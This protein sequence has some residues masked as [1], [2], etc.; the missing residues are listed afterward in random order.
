MAS[1]STARALVYRLLA[2]VFLPPQSGSFE[3]LMRDD[4]AALPDALEAL[5][6]NEELRSRAHELAHE[7]EAVHPEQLALVYEH[8]FEPSGGASKPPNETAHAPEIPQEGLTR[9]YEL[10]D[11]A[12]FY[13]A[14]G[15]EVA[16]ETERVD[17]I[18]A[19]LEF[20][21]L[22]AVKQAL[23]E[24]RG[25]AEHADLCRDAST[26]FLTDHLGRWSG[27]LQIHLEAESAD[28][29]YCAAGSLLASF[30]SADLA[31]A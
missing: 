2:R 20:M 18:A 4:L 3:A 9:T 13:K 16:P 24:E 28:R 21:H 25:E 17:H 19:E 27:K 22:L 14:F 1:D 7:L 12:G 29:V 31:N 8:T 6:A 23:A 10:A 30:V 11:I 5:S 26:K 15:V